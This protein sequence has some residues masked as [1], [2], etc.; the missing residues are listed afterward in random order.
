M[1]DVWTELERHQARRALRRARR[2]LRDPNSKLAQLMLAYRN[3]QAAGIAK[4]SLPEA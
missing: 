2:H 4:W 1:S 3:S